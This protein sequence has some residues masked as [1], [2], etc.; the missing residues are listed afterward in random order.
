MTAPIEFKSLFPPDAHAPVRREAALAALELLLT[1]P[2]ETRRK[3]LLGLPAPALRAIGEQW[4]WQAH[5]GQQEPP[6]A[7]NGDPWRIWAIVAARGFGKTRAGAE[8]VW[9]RA[10]EDGTARI[11]LVAATI[12]EVIRVM[13]MGESGLLALARSGEQPRWISS[14]NM[15]V[16]PSGA[17]AHAF[18]AER[19]EKLRGPQHHYAWCDELAKWPRRV[20]GAAFDNL[21]LGLRLGTR[22]RTIVTTTPRPVPLLKRLLTLP[23]TARTDG[24]TADN[25]HLPPDYRRAMQEMYGNTRLGRQELEGLLLED[26]EGA[27]WTR[28]LLEKARTPSPLGGEGRLAEGERGEGLTRVVIGLDPPAST[29]GDSCGIVICGKDA[30]GTAHV[31]A[32]LTASGLSPEAWA[33]RVAQAA[34]QYGATLIVAEKNQGGD[35]IASVLRAVDTNLPI[36]LVAAT[37]SKA[38]RAEPIA[39]RFE[40]GQAK[41]AGHFPD[42]EDQLCAL[43]W[44]GYQGAGSPDRADAMV[45]AMTEL[46]EKERAEP[47]IMLL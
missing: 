36:R 17:E 10:R 34:A 12:D 19:P 32:D 23:H 15:L 44:S 3:L 1:L 24:A 46:F 22:P 27:L 7:P 20:A 13:V 16:F 6:A 30:D 35:M 8:W 40:T 4:W 9:A 2:R 41:L 21:M 25:P 42:L 11:A 47:R 43:T 45:W 18:S 5:G 38:A 31:L 28:D 14:R 39:L 37:R 33:R 29:N 26:Y